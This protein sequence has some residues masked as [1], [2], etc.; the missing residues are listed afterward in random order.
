[1]ADSCP[2]CGL[3][4][5]DFRR[6]D[7]PSFSEVYREL[8]MERDER[9]RQRGDYSQPPKRARVLGVMRQRKL[10]EWDQHIEWCEQM[11]REAV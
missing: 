11:A 7:A 1:M 2:V 3:A 9:I 8:R 6:P 4:Y 5:R 10:E